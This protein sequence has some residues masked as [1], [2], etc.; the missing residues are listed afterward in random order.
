MK[1]SVI[2]PSVH[3]S[4]SE[5]A[6]VWLTSLILVV[7]LSLNVAIIAGAIALGNALNQPLF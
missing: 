7:G 4:W 5:A 6:S 3:K 1:T 2:H